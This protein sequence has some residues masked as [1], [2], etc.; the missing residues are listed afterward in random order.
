MY[1]FFALLGEDFEDVYVNAGFVAVLAV[2]GQGGGGL[3]FFWGGW[4]QLR[5]TIRTP[6]GDI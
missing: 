4:K 2:S 1:V 6:G 3:F 5:H